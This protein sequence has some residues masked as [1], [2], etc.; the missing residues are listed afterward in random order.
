MF[1]LIVEQVTKYGIEMYT[2]SIVDNGGI[3][4]DRSQYMSEQ[5]ALAWGHRKLGGTDYNVIRLPGNLIRRP[6]DNLINLPDYVN[7][8][9]DDEF[10]SRYT[11]SK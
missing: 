4:V 9:T 1:C 7:V 5:A 6:T 3:Q 10:L 2:V 8:L 11:S